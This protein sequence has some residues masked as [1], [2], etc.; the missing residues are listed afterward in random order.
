VQRPL[1][2]VTVLAEGGGR[3]F[4]T[5]TDARGRYKFEELPAGAYALRPLLPKTLSPSVGNGA[6]V[7]PGG[8]PLT[9]GDAVPP[10]QVD[11][12]A[13][14]AGRV[15][16]WIKVENENPERPTFPYFYLRRLRPGA[17]KALEDGPAARFSGVVVAGEGPGQVLGFEFGAVTP[18]RYVIEVWPHTVYE[19]PRFYYPGVDS[20]ERAEVVEVAAGAKLKDLLIKLPPLKARRVFGRVRTPEGVAVEARVRFTDAS[21]PAATD[22]KTAAGGAFEFYLL[23]GRRFHLSAV[24]E[25]EKGG[26]PARLSAQM[27]NLGADNLPR[28][29][30]GDFGPLELTLGPTA[31]KR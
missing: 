25:G 29:D 2:G 21:Q 8:L 12:L 15:G 4:K 6:A 9:V 1:P 11:F 22:E 5:T 24:Y 16:G 7:P 17:K 14:P 20:L 18:G 10:A 26:P 13:L 30:S 19:V 27:R 31:P 23:E 28:N 3:Q